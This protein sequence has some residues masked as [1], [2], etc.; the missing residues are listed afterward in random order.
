MGGTEVRRLALNMNQIEEYDPP[1][2]F[3][4]ITDSRAKGYIEEFGDNSW[5]LDALEPNIITGLIRDAVEGLRDDALWDEAC[6]EEEEARKVLTAASENWD[7]L[8]EHIKDNYV[9]E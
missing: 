1:P 9:E 8:A 4:K 6:Q 2:N 5:E 7:M 3:A